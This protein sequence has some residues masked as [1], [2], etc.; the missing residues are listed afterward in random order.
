MAMKNLNLSL[1]KNKF[2][3]IVVFFSTI[4][5][6][7]LFSVSA[8]SAPFDAGFAMP[9]VK[10]DMDAMQHDPVPMTLQMLL[11]LSMMT[12]I[13]YMF[14]CCTAFIR[15]SIIFSFLKSSMGLSKGVPK[16][17][18]VGIGLMLTFFVMAPV[19]LQIEK[20]AYD[21]YIHKQISFQQFVSR[22]SKYAMK[23]MQKNTRKNDLAFFVKMSGVKPDS[24]TVKGKGETIKVN[25]KYIRKPSKQGQKYINMIKNPPFHILLAAFMI[26]EMKTGFYI[27]FIIYLP[28]LCID[29]ITAA[30]LMAMGMFMLSPMGFSLPCKM[31]CFVMIDGFNVMS[32]GL[33]KSYRY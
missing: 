22:T 8:N 26:S 33:V 11:Y 16:Q 12:L 3:L 2:N 4:L 24:P 17:V 21:P 27:G 10:V 29:M 31:M 32:E 18:W 14:V 5:F 30:T 1:K 23:F 6:V 13:P 19:A 25:G 15:I 28:F 9:E 7:L 20:N